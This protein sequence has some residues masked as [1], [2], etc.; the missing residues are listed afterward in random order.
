MPL[1]TSP[2]PI[3]GQ[4][5]KFPL[6]AHL[7]PSP[8]SARVLHIRPP[9]R[10]SS[11][12]ED[13]LAEELVQRPHDVLVSIQYARWRTDEAQGN[14]CNAKVWQRERLMR[15][16]VG[17]K[18]E[19]VPSWARTAQMQ[20]AAPLA[21]LGECNSSSCSLNRSI[22]AWT[23]LQADRDIAKA[24]TKL[25]TQDDV[26]RLVFLHSGDLFTEIACL[27]QIAAR[28]V[29]KVEVHFTR[30]DV[31]P[32]LLLAQG[33]DLAPELAAGYNKRYHDVA[34][35]KL[36]Q[37]AHWLASQFTQVDLFAYANAEDL[38]QTALK[39]GTKFHF[40]AVLDPGLEQFEVD[41]ARDEL[42]RLHLHLAV[43]RA[44]TALLYAHAYGSKL[45]RRNTL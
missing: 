35:A 40:F 20:G 10:A 23:R 32:L 18:N 42:R 39:N 31:A 1:S 26:L 12:S 13:R 8:P 37:A 4:R 38:H 33:Q 45:E 11:P 7:Q 5:Q 2:T 19:P 28:K 6:P 41:N 17:K 14:E 30:S 15:Q 16:F 22:N 34:V 29:R 24:A 43:P 25:V 21:S 3:D 36:D 27:Q 44:Q 9:P